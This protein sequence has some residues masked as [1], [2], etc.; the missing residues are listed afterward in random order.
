MYIKRGAVIGAI[1]GGV[2]GIVLAVCIVWIG[3]IFDDSSDGVAPLIAFGL[4]AAVMM[5]AFCAVVGLAIGAVVQAIQ[6]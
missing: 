6:S 1:T 4:F 3:L 2:L 5:T